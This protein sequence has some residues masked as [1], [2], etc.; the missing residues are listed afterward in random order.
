MTRIGSVGKAAVVQ[1]EEPLAY[2]VSLA[3]IRPNH[4]RLN[5]EYLKHWLASP[6]GS[7]ELRKWTLLSATPVKI[8]LGDIGRLQIKLPPI[9]IQVQVSEF[10]DKL[11]ALF[12]D[13]SIGLP[14]EIQA[15]RKQ[16]EYYRNKLLTF[17]ELDAA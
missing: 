12:T 15:R 14:A 10:L 11:E 7:N 3:L 17:K 16:Y 6:M 9:E 1:T 4:E 5:P 2:Y 13:S 8:N